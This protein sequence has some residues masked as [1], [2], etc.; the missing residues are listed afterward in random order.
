MS[1][2]FWMPLHIP[3]YLA[4][5]SHLSTEEHGAYILLIMHYW[6]RNGLPDDDVRLARITRLPLDRWVAMRSTMFGFFGPGWF[7]KRI[8]AERIKA[9]TKFQNLSA[10]GKRGGRPRKE[11][12]PGNKPLESEALQT[13][14]ANG[15]PLE[16]N[17][18]H[19]HTTLPTQQAETSK[20]K[21]SSKQS[22]PD[23][24]QASDHVS[25]GRDAFTPGAGR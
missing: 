17:Y 20:G 11:E 5:T 22:S 1:D 13:V 19:N 6:Q 14:K 15:K 3:D 12:K 2:L 18:I 10:A 4:D 25:L 7:H 16:S 8:D 24:E 9:E 21:H 23:G